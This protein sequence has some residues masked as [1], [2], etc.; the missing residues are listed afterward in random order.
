MARG[1]IISKLKP[2]IINIFFFKWLMKQR[3]HIIKVNKSNR[4][5]EAKLFHSSNHHNCLSYQFLGGKTIKNVN[6]RK[7]YGQNSWTSCEWRAWHLLNYKEASK[8]E[9]LNTL[10]L[11][12][13]EDNA[14]ILMA[15]S[16]WLDIYLILLTNNMPLSLTFLFLIRFSI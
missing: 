8:N 5:I 15:L 12:S 1:A 9:D 3:Q 11:P 10:Q 14:R 4:T 2:Y 16:S 13:E 6:K 7:R